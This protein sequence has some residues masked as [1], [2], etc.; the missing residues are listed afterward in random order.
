VQGL[1]LAIE[2]GECFGLLGPN[3]A[4][5]STTINILTGFLE[6]SRGCAGAHSSCPCQ[7]SFALLAVHAGSC[8]KLPI[9]L[10]LTRLACPLPPCPHAG[11]AIV[12]GHDIRQDMP[13]I[14]SL[15]GVCPQVR[16]RCCAGLLQCVYVELWVACHCESLR[17]SFPGLPCPS[18]LL[19]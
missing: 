8:R 17:S 9:R 15:M 12:E 11:T 2:R 4:G 18:P 7:I 19:C 5:K 14:Y 1:T 10:L 16:C 6:P 13:T 3:G